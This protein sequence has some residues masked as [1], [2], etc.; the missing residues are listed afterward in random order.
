MEHRQRLSVSTSRIALFAVV[1]LWSACV[2]GRE[3]HVAP[4]GSDTGDGSA[5]KPYATIGKAADIA[6][7]GDVVT[8]HAGI[9]RECVKPR[10]GGRSESERITYR[11]ASGEEVVVKGSE[12]IASWTSEGDGVWKV[13][14]PAVFFGDYNPYALTLSGP[15]LN[16][17]QWHHRGDVYLDGEAFVEKRTAAEVRSAKH[18]WHCETN[19]G[20]TTIRAHFGDVDPNAALAEINVRESLFMPDASGLGYITVDGFHFMHSAA[21][22]APPTIP[23]QPGAVGPRMGK[24][25]IIENCRIT[26]ARSVGIILGQAPGVDYDD[27]DAYGEHIVRNN[28]IRRCG[29]AGIA[30]Q[31]GPTRCLIVGNIVEETNYRKEFG[32]W[33]TAAIKFHNTVDTVIEANWIR[34]VHR[35]MQGAFGVWIDFG[36]QGTRISRNLICETEAEGIFLEMNHGPCLVDNNVVVGGGVRSNSEA[37]VFA[38]NLFVDCPFRIGSDTGR[39]SRYFKPHTTIAV[40]RKAGVPREDKWYWNIFVRQ[41]LDNVRKAPGY[42]ADWNV[43]LE[44]AKKSAFGDEHSVVDSTRNRFRLQQH[45]PYGFREVHVPITLRVG[46]AALALEGPWVDGKLVGVFT[47]VGQTIENAAGRPIKVDVDLMGAKRRRPL[48]GPLARLKPGRDRVVWRPGLSAS[49]H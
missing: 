6:R 49:R 38:H 5:A 23:L 44:G 28:L 29:Q 25:W 24:R 2:L 47:T 40:G 36:N 22:W 45:L 11:A 35:Q 16:Y 26:N 46:E 10:R 13:T 37:S 14:L 27:I 21:N 8:V 48:A 32:G 41:G 12:R 9:Y 15:W 34:G 3:I 7:P 19:T 30:G 39:R 31:R 43:Y 42:A 1:V 20:V 17:G 18:S 33:E 4:S